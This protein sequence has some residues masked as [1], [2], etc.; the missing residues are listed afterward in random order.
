MAEYARNKK[1]AGMKIIPS[2]RKRME[3]HDKT[4]VSTKKP[5]FLCC[6]AFRAQY[7]AHAKKNINTGPR[8]TYTTQLVG[9]GANTNA[10]HPQKAIRLSKR[11]FDIRYKGIIVRIR[12]ISEI[13]LA[14]NTQSEIKK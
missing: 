13:N 8:V 14:A 6:I 5:G 7:T 11:S 3:N 10:R 9:K 2:T 1:N 12:K 4:A